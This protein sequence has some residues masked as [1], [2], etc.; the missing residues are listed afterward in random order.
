MSTMTACRKIVE[1]FCRQQEE[2]VQPRLVLVESFS[3]EG[4]VCVVPGRQRDHESSRPYPVE[5]QF[6]IEP[7]AR[8]ARRL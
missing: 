2:D 6:L 8:T 3:A 4:I 5:V 7:S 1:D